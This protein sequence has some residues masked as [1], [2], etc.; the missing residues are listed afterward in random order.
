MHRA[1][2]PDVSG[3]Q[4]LPLLDELEDVHML[5]PDAVLV[6]FEDARGEP[7]EE[8]T[9]VAHQQEGAIVVLQRFLQ[10]ILAL[11]VQMVRGFV[12]DEE[13]QGLQQHAA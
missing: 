7:R 1:G 11:D 3:L 6:Q 2:L 8:V 9:I 13:V 12:K 5:I 4:G 10:H